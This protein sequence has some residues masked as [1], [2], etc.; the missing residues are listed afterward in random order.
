MKAEPYVSQ[1]KHIDPI[2]S[3]FKEQKSMSEINSCQTVAL[4]HLVSGD[5]QELDEKVKS[6]MG[7]IENPIPNGKKQAKLA[8]YVER[9][10]TGRILETTSN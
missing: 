2:K 8:K 6:M 5:L 9:K 4:D 7:E 1:A 10:V 3:L